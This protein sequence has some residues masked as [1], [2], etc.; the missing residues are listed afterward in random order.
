MIIHC[1]YDDAELQAITGSHFLRGDDTRIFMDA[2]V[3]KQIDE[4]GIE[5]VTWTQLRARATRP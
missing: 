2:E 4:M 3:K 1:G 5:I